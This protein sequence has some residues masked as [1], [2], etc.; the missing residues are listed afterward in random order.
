[1]IVVEQKGTKEDGTTPESPD[2]PDVSTDK[3]ITK[4]EID[5][6]IYT[7]EFDGTDVVD[8]TYDDQKRLTR[9]VVTEEDETSEGEKITT[10]STIVFTYDNDKVSYEQTD[11]EDG[12]TSP[13]KPTGS[14]TLDEN[15]RA[16]S[17]TGRD[18]ECKD[19]VEEY[20]FTYSLEYNAYGYLERSVRVEDSDSEE[21]RLI[22][23]NGNLVSVWWGDGYGTSNPDAIDRAQYG[24]VL[25]KT[26]LDLNW[27]IALN[28]EGFDF[29]TG[30]TNKMFPMLGYTGKRS[31]NM[32]E[33]IIAWTG[34][35]KE[36]S[37]YVYTTNDDA[38]PVS[39]TEYYNVAM[40]NEQTD[41]VKESRYRI[42]YNK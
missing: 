33:K 37:K 14:I 42:T 35:S 24:S 3:L 32:V 12:V 28:S 41:W 31:T 34:A 26:N 29:A 1:M 39:I 40:P 22:W 20:T 36:T 16:V 30:D 27:I 18:Y 5:N 7:G 10:V 38:F 11:V 15:C 25:N 4:I 9:M 23:S 2:G 21:E 17:G 8:F 6:Y 19:K 13:Y